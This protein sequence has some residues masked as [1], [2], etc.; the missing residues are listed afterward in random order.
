MLGLALEYLIYTPSIMGLPFP[1][2]FLFVRLTTGAGS[3][4]QAFSP[5][6]LLL[7]RFQKEALDPL[8]ASSW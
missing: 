4:R 1:M 2:T 8:N 6:P 5:G 3:S 7:L